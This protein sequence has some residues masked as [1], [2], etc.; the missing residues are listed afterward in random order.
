MPA[1]NSLYRGIDS[2]SNK[3]TSLTVVGRFFVGSGKLLFL[4][5]DEVAALG[6]GD[7]HCRSGDGAGDVLFLVAHQFGFGFHGSVAEGIGVGAGGRLALGDALQGRVFVCEGEGKCSNAHQICGCPGGSFEGSLGLSL[8]S[9][10]FFIA[11]SLLGAG[12][13]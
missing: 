5:E 3:K 9:A 12:D 11:R 1:A 10:L 13:C 6:E 8:I 7:V 4:A 2:P